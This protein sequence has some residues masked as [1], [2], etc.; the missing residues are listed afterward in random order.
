MRDVDGDVEKSEPLQTVDLGMYIGS[1]LI[2]NIM[3]RFLLIL[4]FELRTLL[5][6]AGTLLVEPHPQPILLWLF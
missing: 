2:K 1:Y 3:E 6:K 5:L 4:V